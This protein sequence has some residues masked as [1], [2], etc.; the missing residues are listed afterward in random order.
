[1]NLAEKTVALHLDRETQTRLAEQAREVIRRRPL[2]R[3]RTPGGLPMRVQVSAAGALGW[4]GDNRGYRYSATDPDGRPWPSM[5]AEW[6]E[7][8]D[9]VAG[10]H[11]WDSAI[12]NWYEEGA[13]LGWHQDLS[14]HDQTLPIVTIS[15]GDD[16]RWG[17]M[18]PGGE[19]HRTIIH[20]GSI[21]LLEGDLRLAH[22]AVERVIPM[23]LL[24][25][26]R[27]RG[28]LSITIRVAGM[29]P[30]EALRERAIGALSRWSESGALR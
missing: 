13:S 27:R 28:R 9:E 11:D 6:R 5:P 10:R 21:T 14:E 4:L 29:P 2:F 25:P 7:I 23:P 1:M 16:A 17:V 26:L 30:A 12:I 22:H 8:A 18:A 3:P 20:S 19:A 15:L 24:S